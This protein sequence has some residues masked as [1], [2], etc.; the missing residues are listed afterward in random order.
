MIA[1][2]FRLAAA[3]VLAIGVVAVAGCGSSSSP[4]GGST[5]TTTP[6]TSTTTT[7]PTTSTTTGA[8]TSTAAAAPIAL[9]A[10]P[11]GKLAFVETTL[12]APAGASTIEFT[13][14]SPVPHNV[15]VEGP[16]KDFGPSTTVMGGGKATLAIDLPAG[17][18][19]FYCA[20]PGHKEAGMV[21]TLT[22]K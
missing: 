2:R 19:Q 8:T 5:A 21:G 17:T 1:L 6:T 20:V 10:D 14:A 22:V 18:Y 16:S 15:E 4:G 9:Q 13:N 12:T 11:S 3:A 7:T